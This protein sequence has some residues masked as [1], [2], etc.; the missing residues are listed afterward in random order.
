MIK[1][2]DYVRYKLAGYY[3]ERAGTVIDLQQPLDVSGRQ[4]KVQ[5]HDI[6]KTVGAVW[7]WCDHLKVM[8]TTETK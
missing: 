6:D 4:A 3:P 2:G 5:W 8:A 1:I 7:E